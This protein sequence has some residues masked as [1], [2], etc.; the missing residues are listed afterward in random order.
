MEKCKHLEIIDKNVG[1]D[2]FDHPTYAFYCKS[3]NRYLFSR[4]ICI[5]CKRHRAEDKKNETRN[6]M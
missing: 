4:S 1:N 6:L 3:D 2:M 5:Q